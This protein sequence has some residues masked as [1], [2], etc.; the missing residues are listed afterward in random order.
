MRV[1]KPVASDDR[2]HWLCYRDR[3]P[4]GSYGPDPLSLFME[5]QLD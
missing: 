1:L 3:G 2:A 5:K 4:F